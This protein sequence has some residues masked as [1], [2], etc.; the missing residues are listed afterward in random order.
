MAVRESPLIEYA[1][2]TRITTLATDTT[3]AA[4]TRHEFAAITVTI[5]ETTTR[6]FLSAWLEFTTRDANTVATDVDGVRMGV[7]VGAAAFADTDLTIATA[8]T[9]DH[10]FN[11][12]RLD[13]TSQMTTNFGA[14]TTASI[15]AAFAMAT[16]AISNVGS[17]TCKL[18]MVYSYDDTAQTTVQK[19]IRIPIQSHFS[20]LTAAQQ[21]IGT[22]GGTA[23]TDA[24]ASQIPVLDTYLPETS[25]VFYQAHLEL[26]A[27][28]STTLAVTDYTPYVQIDAT[29]E[30]ARA[31]LKNALGTNLPWSDLIIYDTATHLTS[32]THALNM[33][34]DLTG[35]LSYVG[36]FL[37]VTYGYAK[38]ST[39]V[40][41]EAMVPFTSHESDH[42]VDETG[43]GG[44]STA[45]ADW[46]NAEFTCREASPTLVQSALVMIVDVNSNGLTLRSWFGSRTERAWG[47]PSSGQ[48]QSN[49]IQRIDFG[50]GAATLTQGVNTFVF[51][52]YS[53][54]ASRG[55]MRG[56]VLFNYTCTAPASGAHTVTMPR[57]KLI[58][59]TDPTA[60]ALRVYSSIAPA[61]I[62]G[63][64]ALSGVMFEMTYRSTTAIVYTVAGEAA[65]GEF[66]GGGWNG[67][68]FN[69]QTGGA[70]ERITRWTMFAFNRVF[71]ETSLASGRLNIETARRWRFQGA[72]S[73]EL[74]MSCW[75]SYSTFT[76]TI[77]G[78]ISGY[79]GDG[80]GI[81]VELFD[82]TDVKISSTTTAVGGTYTFTVLDN[83][84]GYWTQARQSNTLMGRSDDITP[85]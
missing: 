14:G 77:S 84:A 45:D 56:Y 65:A 40:I 27:N 12:W 21:E 79:T 47:V 81:T 61:S 6:T 43:V 44:T 70:S 3:L 67:T 25:K 41:C 64:Y 20:T 35:R 28:E 34:C 60:A 83:R 57:A 50:T 62:S 74:S 11:I 63:N 5:P 52:S 4:A 16:G 37:V 30:V 73:G 18:R 82:P 48:G 26:N 23:T 55:T 54:T 17:V 9:G 72:A 66:S 46:M 58:A 2:V 78:T 80:S 76:Y 8:N 33:R 69:N 42:I 85:S 13:I 36:G 51:K 75:F 29:G 15:Q 31:I 1:F 53:G 22:T 32:T 71:N 7:K 59:Q 39:S 24:P 38:S 68:A 19:T 10:E 49:I